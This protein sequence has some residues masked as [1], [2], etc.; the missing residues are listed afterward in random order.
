MVQ[1]FFRASMGFVQ[2][3]LLPSGGIIDKSYLW[4][5]W[6]D[7][8]FTP[9]AGFPV[10]IELLWLTLLE[11]YLPVID[12]DALAGQMRS[13]LQEGRHSFRELAH[14]GFL[15]DSLDYNWKQ[16]RILTPNGYVAFGLGFPLPPDLARSMVLQARDQLAGR[17]GVRSLAPRDWPSVFPEAFLDDPR[18]HKGKTMASFGIYNYHRGIEWEW[19][20]AFFVAGELQCGGVEEAYREYVAGQVDEAL[21]DA[22]IG[23]L[24][25][26]YDLHGQLGADFQAWSMAAFLES[27]HAFA[28]IHVDAPAGR[29]RAVP[30]IPKEWPYLQVRRRVGTT[31]FDLRYEQQAGSRRIRIKPLDTPPKGVTLQVGV[32]LPSGAR[33]ESATCNGQAVPEEAWIYEDACGADAWGTATFTREFDG[34]VDLDVCIES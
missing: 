2:R 31:R 7:T 14:D 26:L 24:S 12:H 16:H 6:E 9:R 30:W 10:E 27:L 20:N 25:E 3:G 18:S 32:R 13:A 5:T 4:E 11:E 17:R 21:H 22:G 29:V 15:V 23:G 33:V 1:H 8:Q 19:L 34:E 28:G